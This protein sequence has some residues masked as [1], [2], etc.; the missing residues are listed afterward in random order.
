M[1]RSLLTKS[2]KGL[3]PKA[4]LGHQADFRDHQE[5]DSKD[6]QVVSSAQALLEEFYLLNLRV[7]ILL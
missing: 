5:A 3:N 6:L 1:P 7:A 2:H 4:P